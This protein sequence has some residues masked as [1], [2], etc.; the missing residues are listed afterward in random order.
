MLIRRNP[1]TYNKYAHFVYINT[2]STTSYINTHIPHTQPHGMRYRKRAKIIND[3]LT[4]RKI[5]EE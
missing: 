1:Y 3:V 5:V 2:H 4:D